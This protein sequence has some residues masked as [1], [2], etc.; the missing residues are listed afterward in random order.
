MNGVVSVIKPPGMTSHDVVSFMRKV[1]GIKKIGH[2]GTLDPGAAGI[3]PICIGKA[4]KI[5]D[6]IMNDRKTYICELTLGNTTNTY[7]KY[8]EFKNTE[9]LSD[10]K[11]DENLFLGVLDRFKGEIEQIPPAFSAIRINGVRSYELAREGIEVDIPSRKVVIYDIQVLKFS[12][13]KV[14]MQIECSKGTYIRSICNDIGYALGYGGYM[15]FLI[16]TSTGKF[17]LKNSCTMDEIEK[18][19]VEDYIYETDYALNMDSLYVDNQYTKKL[20]NGNSIK[21]DMPT[22]NV[23]KIYKIYIKPDNFIG[24]GYVKDKMLIVEKLMI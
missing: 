3:L 14:L 5:V 24:I 12:Q 8:G 21:L 19:N 4:T 7:D 2:T 20:M 1:T 18:G 6:Y 9:S 23:C 13:T 16:R 11:L 15:S 17:N 10:I 22:N